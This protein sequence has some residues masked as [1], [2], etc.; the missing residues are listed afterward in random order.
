MISLIRSAAGWT[1][2]HALPAV[3]ATV[4]VAAAA[5]GGITYAVASHNT[6]STTTTQPSTPAAP[7]THAK[8]T[9]GSSERRAAAEKLLAL[10]TTDTGQTLASIESQLQGGS[11]MNQVAGA[12]ATKLE[13]DV[14][15]ALKTALDHRVTAGKLTATQES[16]DLARAKTYL[17]KLMA[18]PGTALLK[19]LQHLRQG[20][21]SRLGTAAPATTPPAAPTPAI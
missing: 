14:M 16:A 1:A 7:A 15:A 11:S 13:S 8:K 20:T 12:N 19:Q 10:V 18:E 9:G 6:P 3:A 21:G 17:D 2:Q 4:V 5:G